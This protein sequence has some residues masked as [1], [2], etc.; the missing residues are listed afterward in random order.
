M[1]RSRRLL[2]VQVGEGMARE[3]VILVGLDLRDRGRMDMA[4]EAVG[5]ALGVADSDHLLEL[6]CRVVNGEEGSGYLKGLQVEVVAIQEVT[7]EEAEEGIKTGDTNIS[8]IWAVWV[9]AFSR[10]CIKPKVIQNCVCP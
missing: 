1:E 6:E 3:E 5:E 4:I 7:G 2:A 8:L 9:M 10:Y